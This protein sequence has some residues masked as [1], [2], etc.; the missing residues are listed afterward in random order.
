MDPCLDQEEHVLIQKEYQPLFIKRDKL[1]EQKKKLDKEVERYL[2]LNNAKD[3][4]V[5][6]IMKNELRLEKLQ[7]ELVETK[8]KSRLLEEF[9]EK[10][11]VTQEDRVNDKS[12]VEAISRV[13]EN[14]ATGDI[15][16]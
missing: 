10:S 3:R 9:I 2:R 11:L 15:G 12:K 5:K 8:S 4:G 13:I 1:E 16:N 6:I 14:K 7:K